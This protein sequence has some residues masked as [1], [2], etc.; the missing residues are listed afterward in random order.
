MRLDELILADHIFA[1][2]SPEKVKQLQVKLR[3]E[4][5]MDISSTLALHFSHKHHAYTLV[6]NDTVV[7]WLELDKQVRLFGETYDT[8]KFIYL[9][10]ELRKTRAGGAFL[11]ALKKHLP[12]P[13]ILSSDR[14]GGVLFKDGAQLVKT[15]NHASRA[16]V[17]ILNLQTGEKQPLGDE[18]PTNP[19]H[20]TL[21]FENNTFP[22]RH[23]DFDLFEGAETRTFK[24][25][26]L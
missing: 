2:L 15:L 3:G 5:V 20:L 21:V 17:S 11:V 12:H 26:A 24:D 13:L 1:E 19:S 22:L 25:G 7:G 9:V 16:D 14:Y 23:L 18:L 10:P 8:I 4:K 6:K